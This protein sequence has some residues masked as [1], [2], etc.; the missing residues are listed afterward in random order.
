MDKTLSSD[1]TFPAEYPCRFQKRFNQE[2]PKICYSDSMK[3]FFKF[4]DEKTDLPFYDNEPK[5]SKMEWAL[6]MLAEILFLIPIFFSIEMSDELFSFYLCLIVLLPL[7]YVSKGKMSLFFK[8]VRR[9][10]IKLILLC[11]ILPFA[12]SMFMLFVLESLKISAESP[13][14][15]VSATL[16]SV[17]CMVVQLMGEELFKIILLIIA[18]SVIYHF[19][20]NR[21]LSIIISA[22]LTMAIFGLAHYKYGPIIQIL[23]IQGLGS[24]FD[25]YAYLKTKNVLVSYLAHL[26]FDFAPF[27]LELIAL[28][29]GVSLS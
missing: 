11:T 24:V 16:L 8:K 1:S 14:E 13:I 28:L 20:K 18:M 23:L 5:L 15:P 19:T 22:I 27:A 6:L 9:E 29:M 21:K 12:Y 10:D 2:S 25:L 26:L 7:I 4:E 3:D 17:I